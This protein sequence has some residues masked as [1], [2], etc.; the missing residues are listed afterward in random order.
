MQSRHRSGRPPR[1]TSRNAIRQSAYVPR[2]AGLARFSPPRDQTDDAAGSSRADDSDLED[3]GELGA[4]EEVEEVE[5]TGDGTALSEAS[6]SSVVA[7]AKR[8]ITSWR[9]LELVG[10]GSFGRVYKAVGDLKKQ[11]ASQLQQE[12]VLLSQLEHKNIVQYFGAEKE[13]TV[14]SIFLEFVSEGSLVSVYEKRLLE[15]STVSAY[16]RQILTGFGLS[17]SS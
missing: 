7:V 2:P 14:L 15:E 8:R 12:I 1:L 11:S 5:E 13:E 16:T 4:A 10:A 17:A 3:G 9:K 6:A